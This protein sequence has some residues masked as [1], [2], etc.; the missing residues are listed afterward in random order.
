MLERVVSEQLENHLSLNNL[1]DVFQS[2]YRRHHSTETALL[3][4][5]TDILDALDKGSFVVLIM[6]DLSAAFDTL[7]HSLSTPSVS[8]VMP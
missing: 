4:V 6:I 2:A 1:H 8:L 3:K 7:D 5:Q